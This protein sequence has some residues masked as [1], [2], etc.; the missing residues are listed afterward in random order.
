MGNVPTY[1]V[2]GGQGWDLALFHGAEHGLPPVALVQKR[3]QLGAFD[4]YPSAIANLGMRMA[5]N[6]PIG[7]GDCCESGSND[8]NSAEWVETYT[9]NQ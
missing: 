1:C 6:P 8:S 3:L 4:A 5:E 9:S 2:K 7:G